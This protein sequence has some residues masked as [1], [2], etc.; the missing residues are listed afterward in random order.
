[1]PTFNPETPLHP[2]PQPVPEPKVNPALATSD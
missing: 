2:Q 1:V